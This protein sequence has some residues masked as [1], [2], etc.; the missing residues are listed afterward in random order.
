MSTALARRLRQVEEATR[1]RL[2][3]RLHA[4]IDE[5]IVSL[6]SEHQR[7]LTDGVR[8]VRAEPT[9]MLVHAGRSLSHVCASCIDGYDPPALLRA[10][11]ILLVHRTLGGAP[12]L[13]PPAIA[14]VYDREPAARP[15]VPCTRCSYLLPTL[16]GA[17]VAGV[18]CPVCEAGS[19]PAGEEDA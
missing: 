12:A 10:A 13:L 1:D 17:V 8:A 2:L 4:A 9:A 3:R 11:W 5:Q 19:D 16:R 7:R 6:T 15:A 18:S 14:A